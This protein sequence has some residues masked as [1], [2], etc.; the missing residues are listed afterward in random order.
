MDYAPACE[1][2]VLAYSTEFMFE[3]SRIEREYLLTG[4]RLNCLGFGFRLERYVRKFGIIE[5]I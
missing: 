5:V 2:R 3:S 1:L 4:F